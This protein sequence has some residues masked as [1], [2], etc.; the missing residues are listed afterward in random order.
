MIITAFAGKGQFF[1]QHDHALAA[2]ELALHWGNAEFA[3]LEPEYQEEVVLATR[4]HDIGW[5]RYDQQPLLYQD[6]Q[7]RYRAYDFVRF[8]LDKKLGLYR[9]GVDQVQQQSEYAAL[10]CSMHY[11][12]FVE[13]QPLAARYVQEERER[14][15][16]IMDRLGR[17]GERD[18][19]EYHFRLL[20][21]WDLL[22]LLVCMTEPGSDP[23]GWLNWFG[24]GNIGMERSPG[25]T[26]TV[27]VGWQGKER[28]ALDPFPFDAP[29]EVAIPYLELEGISFSSPQE[30]REQLATAER[31]VRQVQLFP[32]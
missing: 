25:Q 18:R 17:K 1:A 6:G 24:G 29:F 12:R 27:K 3:P 11:M 30:W 32:G 15:E 8:P 10:L 19:V 23:E 2:G 31:K 14:Q 4:L 16:R 22:S 28:L 20:R 7:G 26:V 13:R 5:Q 9:R 21:L